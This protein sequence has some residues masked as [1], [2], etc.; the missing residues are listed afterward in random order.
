[1]KKQLI[2]MMAA[3]MSLMTTMPVCGQHIYAGDD[4]EKVVSYD[5]NG[6]KVI[7]LIFDPAKMPDYIREQFGILEEPITEKPP[8][9]EMVKLVTEKEV[10]AEPPKTGT[11]P[12]NITYTDETGKVRFTKSYDTFSIGQ[13]TWYA[14]GRFHETYGVFLPMMGNAK[15]WLNHADWSDA[16]TAVRDIDNIEGKTIAVYAPRTGSSSPGHVCFIEYVERDSNGK[17]LYVYYTDANGKHDTKKNA[18]T[19]NA[20]GKVIKE[21][22]REFQGNGNLKLIGY[23]AAK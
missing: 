6:G 11:I 9:V 8:A 12:A 17:P 10:L 13:C 15:E 20:D 22:F 4:V 18:Y 21:S 1:M 3:T 16:V 5:E 19:K 2:I 14:R 7:T 23:L